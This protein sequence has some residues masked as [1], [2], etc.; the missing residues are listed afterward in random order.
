MHNTYL[1]ND[2]FL[3]LCVFLAL[4]LPL[5]SSLLSFVT[6]DRYS[7][8]IILNAPFLLLISTVFSIIVLLNGWNNTP[9]II[10]IAWLN[11]G[12]YTISANLY[13][14][15]TAALMMAVVSVISF[16]V[17]LYSVGY[18]AGDENPRKYFGMLGLFT[19]AMQGIV[20]SDNLL[21]LFIFWE[22]VGFSSYVLIGHWNDRESAGQAATNAFLFNRIGDAAFLAGLMIVW[23]KAGTFEISLL[24]HQT[25]FEW[26]TLAGILIF[27]GVI[28]K[29]AQ[30]P[31]FT[32]LPD[33]MEG[34][35]PVSALIHAAT[36]VAAGVY[37]LIRLFPLY[38][39][40][41]LSV[42]AF[43]GLAT[44]VAAAVA[45]LF[46]YDI[47]RVLAYST[48]SQLGLMIAA[49]GMGVV[50]AA[51]LHLFTHAFFKACLFLCAG[52]VI[53]SLHHAQARTENEF[54]VQDLRN[55][56][57]LRKKLP[58]TF[59]TFVISGASL[60]GLPFFSG[61]LSKEAIFSAIAFNN[62]NG[63][64]IVLTVMMGVSFITVLYTFRLIWYI[65]MGEARKQ[66]PSIHEAPMIMRLPMALLASCSVWLIVS[67]N[68][69]DFMGWMIPGNTYT[70]LPWLTILSALWITLALAVAYFIFRKE[71]F[72]TNTFIQQ[73]YGLDSFYR[74]T[75]AKAT[76]QLS[77]AVSF[78]DRRIIDGSIHAGA[79][80]HVTLAHVVG[81]IDKTIVDGS[82]RF[83]AAIVRGVGGLV[84]SY[85]SG[86][87]QDY[88]LYALLAL[89][90]FLI[91][92]L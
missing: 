73:G 56:G 30:I 33:A 75:F 40:T 89:I 52:S 3:T 91:W 77:H 92:T 55:L 44:S 15:N 7:W 19:F 39:E 86:K 87:I 58:V 60:A 36:M 49:I 2:G 51:L 8:L 83:F 13:L 64:W 63:S 48:I 25:S 76:H 68:P 16:L 66:V 35:T 85:Q 20:M 65:F 6:S 42:I 61:F 31:L 21:V 5:L 53:H 81:W 4:L 67:W 27:G 88:I 24:L 62:H 45:A 17:H 43:T 79:Y 70:H 69:F 38:T 22:L 57:G 9:A 82:V 34:P 71:R 23:S 18:M 12:Q 41:S 47:K 84:R 28:G 32:W 50:H 54:D 29:S 78:A 80:G 72:A 26:Q 90:I 74:A 1:L 11:L 37:L 10:E 59:L 46:Q 14:S